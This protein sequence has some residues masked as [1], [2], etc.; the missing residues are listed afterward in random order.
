[1]SYREPGDNG[2]E[3]KKPQPSRLQRLRK[4]IWLNWEYYV[5]PIV[6]IGLIGFTIYAV[7]E[8]T[9]RSNWCEEVCGPRK[10]RTCSMTGGDFAVCFGE[11]TVHEKG[12]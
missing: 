5:G 10:V 3:W 12:E 2:T 6:V 7:H 8:N 4:W 9:V 1:M 11:N